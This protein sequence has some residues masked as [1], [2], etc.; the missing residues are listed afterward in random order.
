MNH[1]WRSLL[2]CV[3]YVLTWQRAL[4]AY[5]PTCLACLGAHVPTCLACSRDNVPCVLTYSGANAPCVLTCSRANVPCVLT[6]SRALRA[7]RAYVLTWHN[8][9]KFSIASFPYI[10]VI[11]LCLFPVK[12]KR[13]TFLHV[14]YHVEAIYYSLT[15]Q[16]IW[17]KLYLMLILFDVYHAWLW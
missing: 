8:K 1:I 14:S 12:Q 4:R 7:L 6:C 2:N 13:Y 17:L 3:P 16:Y 10:F 5:V 15:L 11:V 9:N